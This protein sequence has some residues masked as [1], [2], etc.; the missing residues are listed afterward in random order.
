MREDGVLGCFVEEFIDRESLLGCVDKPHRGLK[1][2]G[3]RMADNSFESSPVLDLQSLQGRLTSTLTVV[4]FL[5]SL[6]WM[7]GLAS[8]A[9]HSDHSPR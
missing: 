4:E 8:P 3:W 2:P 9:D 1:C 6:G 5:I 7:A